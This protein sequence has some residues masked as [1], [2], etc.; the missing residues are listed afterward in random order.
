MLNKIQQRP[1]KESK[2]NKMKVNIIIITTFL[3][4]FTSCISQ[5]EVIRHYQKSSA[6]PCGVCGSKKHR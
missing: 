2:G 6:T 3:I 4:F 5:K 1:T